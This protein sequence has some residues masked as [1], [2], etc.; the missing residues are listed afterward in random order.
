MTSDVVEAAEANEARGVR[1]LL[2][3]DLS[4]A[5]DIAA[6]FVASATWP[7]GTTVRIVTSPAG[8]GGPLSSFAN[9]SEVRAHVGEVRS[10]IEDEH[11]DQRNR[12]HLQR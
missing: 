5:A 9:L 3:H 4:D 11:G 7:P 1:I 2:A 6:T 8:I 12:K 10:W